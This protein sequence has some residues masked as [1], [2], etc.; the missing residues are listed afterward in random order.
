M[1]FRQLKAR[2]RVPYCFI[3]WNDPED[4]HNGI[5]VQGYDGG[6]MWTEGGN[7]LSFKLEL[8]Y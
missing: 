5:D 1:R 4:N 3:Y 8:I 2:P 7:K 6:W